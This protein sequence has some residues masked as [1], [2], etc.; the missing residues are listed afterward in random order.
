MSERTTYTRPLHTLL[1]GMA[2]G[3]AGC[4]QAI[5]DPQTPEEIKTFCASPKLQK[6][7]AAIKDLRARQALGDTCFRNGYYLPDKPRAW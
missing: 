1:S 2:L 6:K 4:N 3:L 5:P 7:L